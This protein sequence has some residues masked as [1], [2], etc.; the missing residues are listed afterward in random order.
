MQD[1]FIVVVAH[2]DDETLWFGHAIEL[3]KSRVSL[4]IICLTNADV[5]IRAQEF[6]DYCQC[7]KVKGSILNLADRLEI[8]LKDLEAVLKP[9]FARWKEE[10]KQPHII[11]HSP[12]GDERNHPQH[13]Q[14][15]RGLSKL[16]HD[17]NFDL[18]FFSEKKIRY[19]CYRA[20]SGTNQVKT[21]S[22]RLD[23][24]VL[25]QTIWSCIRE[26]WMHPRKIYSELKSLCYKVNAYKNYTYACE[27]KVDV[28][29][30]QQY[31]K[32]Y[33]SQ[34]LSNYKMFSQNYEIAYSIHPILL[35]ALK[36]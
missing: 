21:Y 33:A 31:L 22:I 7:A 32:I 19:Y 10:R 17:Y 27:I 2:P 9:Y 15:Y 8:S 35:S 3:L 25:L 23:Y 1:H 30:K 6:R 4:E 20:L 36:D 26:G 5:P 12:H 18:S 24:R 16:A 13:I 14:I 11:T 28:P 34:G 29:I